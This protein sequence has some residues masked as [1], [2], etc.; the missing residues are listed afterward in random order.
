[1]AHVWKV[2]SRWS[3]NGAAGTSLINIFRRSNYVFVGSSG[4]RFYESVRKND[5]LAIADGLTIV[6]VAKVL[7]DKP[8]DLC[9]LMKNNK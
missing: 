2:G 7:D 4:E 9:E 3:S 5:Y 1:M 6:A 8:T